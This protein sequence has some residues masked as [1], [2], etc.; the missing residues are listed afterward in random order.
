MMCKLPVLGAGVTLYRFGNAFAYDMK[1]S[2]DIGWSC[3]DFD[4]NM[5]GYLDKQVF[6]IKT[7]K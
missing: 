2:F 1:Q 6:C 4:H 7:A 3:H 5:L